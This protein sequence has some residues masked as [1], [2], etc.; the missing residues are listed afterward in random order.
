M[1]QFVTLGAAAGKE[2]VLAHV[3]VETFQT[4]IPDEMHNNS[5]SVNCSSAARF[6]RIFRQN[7]WQ[8]GFTLR[9]WRGK[10]F[11]Y[12]QSYWAASVKK[13]KNTIERQCQKMNKKY[14]IL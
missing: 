14:F 10:R 1:R 7:T 11:R 12:E 9:Q 13:I 8:S 4:A 6:S 5:V 3:E 2:A